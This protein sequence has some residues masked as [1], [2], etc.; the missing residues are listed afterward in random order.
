MATPP[1]ALLRS[2]GRPSRLH[3]MGRKRSALPPDP[4]ERGGP[5]PL[6]GLSPGLCGSVCCLAYFTYRTVT[7]RI[8]DTSVQLS[9]RPHSGA[10]A[11]CRGRARHSNPHGLT[12]LKRNIRETYSPAPSLC[13]FSHRYR[14]EG[15]PHAYDSV[16]EAHPGLA[17][18]F[19]FY[20][21]G[22]PHA[23]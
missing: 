20:S 3:P 4:S 5:P 11:N 17:S 21:Q 8:R 7:Q 23:A 15:D 12:V 13:N 2:W 16:T 1:A 10:C 6:V 14:N 9:N 18:H 19:T 22:R